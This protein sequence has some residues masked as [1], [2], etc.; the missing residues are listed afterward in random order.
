[1]RRI[2]ALLAAACIGLA[3]GP[4]AAHGPSAHDAAGSADTAF[5]RAGDRAHATRTVQIEMS[6]RMRFEPAVIRVKAGE[7]VR[8]VAVNRGAQ[9]HELVLGTMEELR[10]HAELMRKFP[11]ME[12]DDPNMVRVPPG[13]RGE[14]VWQFT[15]PGEFSYACL[16]PGHFEAGMVGRVVVAPQMPR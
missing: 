13:A 16:M 8:L 12:H 6:D 11:N 15:K 2:P 9:P 14:I 10:E 4:L 1:M 3:A 7:T 5:G